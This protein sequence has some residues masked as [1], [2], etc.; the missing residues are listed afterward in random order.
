MPKNKMA[1]NKNSFKFSVPERIKKGLSPHLMLAAGL[2]IFFAFLA[3]RI[4]VRAEFLINWDAVNY[5]LGTKL[6]SL[7]HH[8][9]HPPG[10]IGYVALGWVLNHLTG[11]ANSS[12]TLLS[13]LSG[14]A[15][16]AA[17]FLLGSNFMRRPYAAVAAATFG[18]SPLVWYYSE[19]ALGYSLAM[20]LALFFLWAGYRAWKEISGPHLFWATIFLVL[21]GSVRQSGALFLIPLWLYM[22]W[23][24]P[25]RRRLQAGAILVAGNLTWLIPLIVLAGDV[26]A[27]FRAAADLASLAVAPT[28]LF[29]FDIFGLLR[30]F[31]FVA[32]GILVGI[33]GGLLIIVLARCTGCR[34]LRGLSKGDKTFF[35][36]WLVPSLATYVLIHTGQLGY[37]LM[38]LPIGFIWAGMA[39]DAMARQAHETHLLAAAKHRAALAWKSLVLSALTVM[40]ALTN[41]LGSLYI[42]N[43]THTLTST[44]NMDTKLLAGLPNLDSLSES[45]RERI[46]NW[47]RQFNVEKN[48]AYW[49]GLI[50]LIERFDPDTTAV[51]AEPTGSGSFRHLTYYLPEFR[52]YGVGKDIEKDFGYLFKAHNSSSDYTVQ[53]LEEADRSLRLPEGITRIIIPD[54]GIYSGLN[55]DQEQWELKTLQ[56]GSEVL[57]L[58]VPEQSLL[59]FFGDEDSDRDAAVIPPLQD[60]L[61]SRAQNGHQ[62]H[63]ITRN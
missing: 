21:L 26:H 56:D 43:A 53:G 36:L 50:R 42:P 48:D 20:A 9:P 31:S 24:F 46:K 22:V 13:A 16:P 58:E 23:P 40:F 19:V 39:L 52:I 61:H 25:W 60:R 29:S 28:S 33:N 32:A 15:A 59:L 45:K 35:S 38:V 4:P 44:E 47:A 6:F 62:D 63:S 2:A 30:N 51:L 41:V 5:A 10:Y 8:Q 37:I 14:A 12:L 3:L 1:L 11:D 27:Y 34:P 55:K 49:K 57:V 17:L 7:E 18:L 54:K